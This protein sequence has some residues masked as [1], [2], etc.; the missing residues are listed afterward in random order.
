MFRS[1]IKLFR[2]AG[3]EIRLDLS[4]FIIFAIL[5]YYF[6]FTYFPYVL[7]GYSNWLLALA[8]IITVV[9]FFFSVLAHELSHSLVAKKRGLSV[10]R[11]SLWIFGGM[12]EIEKEPETPFTE[13]SM[14]I[15]GPVTSFVLGGIFAIIWFFT[16]NTPPVAEP[17]AYLA[18]INIILGI[19]N[20]VPGYPLD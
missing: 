2:I 15:I 12:A 4:W 19:F 9:L 8:T 20:L 3:I 5:V 7:P 1:S 6:G 10:N 11:I 16:R 14:A 18:Q 17:A 13:F